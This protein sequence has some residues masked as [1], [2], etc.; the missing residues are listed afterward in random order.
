MQRPNLNSNPGLSNVVID[1]AVERAFFAKVYGWM[2]L[3][4]AITGVVAAATASN[5]AYLALFFG[6]GVGF[7]VLIVVQFG[8]VIALSALI[9]KLSATLAT[10]LFIIYAAITG[11]TFS[12][13]FLAFTSESIAAVFFITAGTFAAFSAIG[14]VT[15]RDLTS[16]GSL[17][18]MALIGVILASLVNLFLRSEP[19]Y[20]IISFVA[21]AV[22]VG[23]IAY[24]TQ[25]IKRMAAGMGG[26]DGEVQSKAAI[27]GAL[28]LY[29]DFINL[30][31][32][33]LMIFGKRR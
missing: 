23:L 16:L 1:Q 25:R 19:L 17:G 31:I 27:H 32:R 21:I 12:T 29:L 8:V 5:P 3:A 28:A 2:T 13:L 18:I 7:L 9:N 6:S 33:L 10:A 20:W 11:V 22:F 4:L 30:F 15:K 26:V 24:D 14:Y